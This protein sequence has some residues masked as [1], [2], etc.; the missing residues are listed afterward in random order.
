MKKA[1]QKRTAKSPRPALQRMRFP[2][3]GLDVAQAIRRRSTPSRLNPEAKPVALELPPINLNPRFDESAFR[4]ELEMFRSRLSSVERECFDDCRRITPQ[5]FD[6]LISQLTPEQMESRGL[7]SSKELHDLRSQRA[8][9]T[10]SFSPVAKPPPRFQAILMD[11]WHYADV[12]WLDMAMDVLVRGINMGYKG[13]RDTLIRGKN[14][15]RSSK[16]F[17]I[18]IETWEKDF[19]QG[20]AVGWFPE[21]PF[22]TGIVNGTGATRKKD[23]TW[24]GID[25]LSGSGLNQASDKCTI[26]YMNFDKTV[27]EFEVVTQRAFRQGATAV[28]NK[29]DVKGAYKINPIHPADQH[30]TQVHIPSKGYAY[31]THA[32]FEGAVYGYRW[33]LYGGSLLSTSYHVADRCLHMDDQGEIH[34][35]QPTSYDDS[36]WFSRW[37]Q[38]TSLL[39]LSH[40]AATD[41]VG[42][43]LSEVGR[44]RLKT[45]K[46]APL[47]ISGMSRWVDDWYKTFLRSDLAWRAAKGISHIHTRYGITLAEEKFEYAYAN[48]TY[49]GIG[50]DCSTGKLV[51]PEDKRARALTEC[52]T[53]LEA[54]RVSLREIQSAVGNALFIT[55][56]LEPGRGFMAGLYEAAHLFEASCKQRDV[57]PRAR[58]FQLPERA[59][60]S[61]RFFQKMLTAKVTSR[62]ALPRKEWSFYARADVVIHVDWTPQENHVYGISVLSHG[63]WAVIRPPEELIKKAQGPISTSSVIMEGG[64]VKYAIILLKRLIKGKRVLIFTD[65][66]GFQQVHEKL[67]SPTPE[68]DFLI[69]DI[70]MLQLEFDFSLRLEYVTTELNLS[71]SLSHGDV[72]RFK[73]EHS[74]Q[75]FSMNNSPVVP[76]FKVMMP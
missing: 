45:I 28:S 35:S 53:L 47:G 17:D 2:K 1:T 8:K 66:L 15:A 44:G 19:T 27:E 71:D 32:G 31:R 33:E 43:M 29:H 49:G 46:Q 63:Q 70:A 48:N 7:R 24:R 26:P 56:V 72:Q 20:N 42:I 54:E 65:N 64:A 69:Q 36:Q 39:D 51:Y 9:G 58:L 12:L 50:F 3:A 21:A 74:A 37:R 16:D 75:G 30:L 38:Y 60:K 34:H 25:D 68:V 52:T 22:D 11:L 13:P 73:D 4:K 5:Q 23:G 67:S 61:M 6:F 59:K 18:A 57:P 40:H 14:M 76:L 62:T 55:K 10:P 41:G